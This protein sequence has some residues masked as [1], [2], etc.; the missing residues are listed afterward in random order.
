VL[1]AGAGPGPGPGLA[2]L[3]QIIDCYRLFHISLKR[4]VCV[5]VH[6]CVRCTV[7]VCLRERDG[8]RPT[9]GERGSYKEGGQSYVTQ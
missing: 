3:L 4:D 6:V 7:H 2:C 8:R 1:V 5:H 9:E